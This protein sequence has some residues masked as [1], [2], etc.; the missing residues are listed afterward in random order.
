MILLY[1]AMSCIISFIILAISSAIVFLSL[2]RNTYKSYSTLI[3]AAENTN[4]L[5][6]FTKVKASKS[7]QDHLF[8]INSF[9]MAE[10]VLE[11][12]ATLKN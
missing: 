3:V 2:T 7:L 10:K 11:N 1:N 5:D 4:E 8:Y 6:I 12:V 9:K